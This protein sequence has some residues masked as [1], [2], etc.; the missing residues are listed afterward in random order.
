MTVSG[1]G[2]EMGRPTGAATTPRVER[3]VSAEWWVRGG[4]WAGIAFVP[5]FVARFVAFLDTPD[6]DAPVSE[7][8]EHFEDSGNRMQSVGGGYLMALAGL[9]FLWFL[10][11]LCRRLREAEA[12]SVFLTGLT[13]GGGLLFVAMVFASGAAMASV[14]AGVEFGDTPA[15]D[16]EFARQL[17]GLGFG[18]LL[19]YG[20]FAAGICMVAASIVS[21]RRAVLPRWLAIAGIVAGLL[22][23]PFGV[24]FLPLVLLALWVLAVAIVLIRTP[25]NPAP[26]TPPPA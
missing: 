25:A 21:L 22:V 16:G 6:G 24:I 9:A 17:E 1:M 11:A 7:W 8:T 3:A 19:L 20:M 10:V 13:F 5:L 26:A 15:P 2:M 23:I 4:A 12:P 14:A 18:L